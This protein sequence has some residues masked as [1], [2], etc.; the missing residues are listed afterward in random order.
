MK[1]WSMFAVLVLFPCLGARAQDGN[2]RLLIHAQAP[3]DHGWTPSVW[4][5]SPNVAETPDKVVVLAGARS[6]H[7]KWWI[8]VLGGAVVDKDKTTPIVEFR[9]SP[10]PL[11]EHCSTWASARLVDPFGQSKLYTYAQIDWSLPKG[12]GKIGIETENLDGSGSRDHSIGPHVIVPLGKSVTLTTAYQL[13]DTGDDQ[14][15]FRLKFEF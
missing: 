13:H 6:V 3:A 2:I 4:V 1:F 11:S 12:L 15:W 9:L 5:I 8:D 14:L 7:P 10:P